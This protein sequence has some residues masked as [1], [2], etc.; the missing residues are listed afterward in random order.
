VSILVSVKGERLLWR[1]WGL[2]SSDIL[3]IHSFRW[4][5]CYSCLSKW[6]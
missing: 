4:V 6:L 3:T 5:L 2:S 1:Y